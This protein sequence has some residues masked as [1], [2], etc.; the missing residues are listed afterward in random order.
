MHRG[1]AGGLIGHIVRTDDDL[2]IGDLA[3]RAGILAGHP[4]RTPSL[5]GQPGVVQHQD[6]LRRTLRDQGPHTLLVECPGGPDRIGY[7]MLEPFGRGLCDR[8]SDGVT[9]LVRQVSQ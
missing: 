9:V 5:F 4:H 1:A 3:Q 8:G 6:A 7:E 2:T